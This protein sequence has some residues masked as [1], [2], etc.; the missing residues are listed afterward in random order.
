M[1]QIL[2]IEDKSELHSVVNES[3]QPEH[4]VTSVST[5]AEARVKLAD[6]DW[7][8][9]IVDIGLSDGN[10]MELMRQTRF[11]RD[12]PFIFLTGR[13]DIQD[14][15]MAFE[16]GAQDYLTKPFDS[17]ELKARVTARLQNLGKSTKE[18]FKNSTF[19]IEVPLQRVFALR[20]EGE[21]QLNLTPIEFKI[22]YYF[23]TNE[24]R[25]INRDEILGVVWGKSVNV[26]QRTIDKHISSLR[27]KLGAAARQIETIPQV[28][29]RY[30]S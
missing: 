24:N 15:L 1:A 3:L 26:L 25:I 20:P 10:G 16:A 14:K 9:L 29:Y 22:L 5:A 18:N 7:D 27:Q 30:I 23:C 11:L 12:I 4:Q 13:T 8:L 21:V 17:R 2:F 6:H 28:G 19:R